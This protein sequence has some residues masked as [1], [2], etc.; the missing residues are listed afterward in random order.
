MLLQVV[1]DVI[2]AWCVG[3]GCGGWRGG[4]GWCHKGRREVGKEGGRAGRCDCKMYE[5][6]T[7]RGKVTRGPGNERPAERRS[8][9][10]WGA[11][12]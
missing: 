3:V 10:G 8:A 2:M 4:C 6:D 9:H 7:E 11:A 1:M 5:I 12:H